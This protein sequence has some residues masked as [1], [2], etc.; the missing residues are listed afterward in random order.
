MQRNR[1]LL[2]ARNLLF[3]V[4]LLGAGKS[5][6]AATQYVT[7]AQGRALIL[8]GLNTASSS[9]NDPVGMPWISEADVVNETAHMGT[10]VVRFLIFW[11]LV[12]PQPGQFDDRYLADVAMRIAWYR[13]AGMYVILDMHQDLYGPAAC[14]GAAVDVDG[15]PA[16]ATHTDGLPIVPQS[17]WALTY[18]QPGEVRAFDYFWGTAPGH[19]ELRREFARAWGHVA[20]YF[21]HSDAV[22]G[23]DL[24]NEPFGGTIEPPLFEPVALLPTYQAV[25]QQ[26]RAVDSDHWL[27][28][29]P[30]AFPVN[31]GLPTDLPAPQ[32]PRAG[33]PHIVYAP[34]LY[35]ATVD[36]APYTGLNAV[37]TDIFVVTWTLSNTGTAAA[38]NT[39]LLIGEFGL[40]ATQAGALA[41]VDKITEV[42]EDVGANWC[43]WSNDSGGWGPYS[44]QGGFAPLADHLARP[45]ARAI[46]GVP[47][48][49][50]YNSAT[51][52][53]TV[54]FAR[55]AGVTGTTDVFLS[56]AVYANGYSLT[57]TDP[58]GSYTTAFDSVRNILSITADPESPDHTYIITPK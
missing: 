57:T 13:S 12:E 21:A 22:L 30:S 10:D 54:R 8:H 43:W 32:D 50:R 42:A 29:E 15:A 40:N 41:Y 46:A 2:L 45:Y 35:P 1:T 18:L 28:I 53:L 37:L 39:P 38:W 7:D 19:P 9:K 51:G 33:S 26:I 5:A 36:S 6:W 44:S 24:F 31:Q 23:F 16:W 56:P 4:A 58:T 55:A 11:D 25:I 47:E 17:L 34:H 52:T 3:A 14:C 49:L 48:Q 27:F 20:A